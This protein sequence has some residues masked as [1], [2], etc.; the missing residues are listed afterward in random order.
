MT[1]SATTGCLRSVHPRA[2]A[3][4]SASSW[5][6]VSIL[7]AGEKFYGRAFG[8]W[9]IEEMSRRHEVV[10]GACPR[11]SVFL[12]VGPSGRGTCLL[13]RPT[14]PRLGTRSGGAT[15]VVASGGGSL[16]RPDAVPISD[17]T[18]RSSSP[19]TSASLPVTGYGRLSVPVG[20]TT[21]PSRRTCRS[22]RRDRG[23]D[24]P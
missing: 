23:T 15:G 1:T 13:F 14:L 10:P 9:E 21:A 6:L 8:D 2:D 11:C 22:S 16:R 7:G 17:R 5:A 18:E 19:G 3:E 4:G 24:S 12:R 20:R